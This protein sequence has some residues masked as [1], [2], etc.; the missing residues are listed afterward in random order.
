MCRKVYITRSWKLRLKKATLGPSITAKT[1]L[2]IKTV[3]LWAGRV[4]PKCIRENRPPAFAMD[5]NPNAIR[6]EDVIWRLLKHPQKSTTGPR[7][8]SKLSWYS[9]QKR[10]KSV[11]FASE[12]HSREIYHRP[13]RW[14]KTEPKFGSEYI[15]SRYW[16]TCGKICHRPSRWIRTPLKTMPNLKKTDPKSHTEI[17]TTRFQ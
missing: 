4:H 7:D 16:K 2:T 14:I 5:R 1:F 9:F 15:I 11:K 8:D 3:E 6:F 13:S 17:S 10:W 12:M